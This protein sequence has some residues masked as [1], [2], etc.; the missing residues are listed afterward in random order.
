MKTNLE[1]LNYRFRKELLNN[2]G[3]KLYFEMLA[4]SNI[5][6]SVTDEI[7]NDFKYSAWVKGLFKTSSKDNSELYDSIEA[8]FQESLSIDTEFLNEPYSRLN[9]AID[10]INMKELVSLWVDLF[11]AQSH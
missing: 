10:I 4:N 9:G 5:D 3:Y 2:Y 6:R 1:E 7:P 8:M 11:Y